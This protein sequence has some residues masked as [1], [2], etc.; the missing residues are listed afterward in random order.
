[1][2]MTLSNSSADNSVVWASD[3]TALMVPSS[4]I[5]VSYTARAL[6][7]KSQCAS[8]TSQ[9]VH[10][11]YKSDYNTTTCDT[12]PS[13]SEAYLDFNC[14][15]LNTSGVTIESGLPSRYV[16]GIIDPQTNAPYQYNNISYSAQYAQSK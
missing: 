1:M 4:T 15:T 5:N 2:L 10:C 14:P 7:I 9:C 3:G 8:I 16:Q 13:S 12:M 11:S 6:G